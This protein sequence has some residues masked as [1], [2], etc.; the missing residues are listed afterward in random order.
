MK[1]VFRYVSFA[2]AAIV[3]MSTCMV[4]FARDNKDDL[5]VSANCAIAV[6]GDKLTVSGS[7]AA[8]ASYTIKDKAV[9]F[10]VD[11]TGLILTY[12]AQGG[13]IKTIRLGKRIHA[14]NVSGT[15]DA[16]TLDDTLDYHYTVTVDATVG[17]LTANGDVKLL[18][19]GETAIDTLMLANDKAV[20]TAESEVKIKS[21]NRAPDS[22]TYLS[23][24]V[25]D[26][27]ANT[28]AASYDS[29]T[30]VLSLTANRAGCTV[31][32]AL[33]DV[34][35]TVRQAHGDLAVAGRWYW[36]NLDGGATDSGRYLY[37]FAPTAQGKG[38]Q[39]LTVAFTKAESMS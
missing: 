20:V 3:L 13:N 27:R 38:V 23:V 33:K 34:V 11:G 1:N 7:Y 4:A 30:G 12:P 29:A 28:S 14:F 9:T 16:L 39:E 15:F 25:R 6:E 8:T 35:M 32:D 26:Y 19:T 5:P 17:Q 36:P 31:T 37:R 10:A 24:A 22:E 21:T 2:A 18:L